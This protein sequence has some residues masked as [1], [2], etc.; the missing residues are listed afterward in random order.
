M[1]NEYQRKR[2]AQETTFDSLNKENNKEKKE[3][4]DFKK[5]VDKCQE[6]LLQ[7]NRTLKQVEEYNLQMRSEIAIKRRTTYKAEEE[8][9]KLEKDKEK[10]DKLIDNLNEQIKYLSEQKA[11]LSTQLA[12]QEE[13]TNNAKQIL[14]EALNEMERIKTSKN[15]IIEDWQNTLKDIQERDKNLTKL[16]QFIV[17]EEL[18]ILTLNS[19]IQGINREHL[20]E[21]ANNEQNLK[22]LEKNAIEQDKLNSLYENLETDL[23]RLDTKV[24]ML[25]KSINFKEEEKHKLEIGLSEVRTQQV[26][27]EDGIVKNQRKIDDLHNAQINNKNLKIANE[28]FINNLEKINVKTDEEKNKVI[29]N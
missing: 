28:N 27:M 21:A 11:V 15:S 6:E 14:K 7:L 3:V 26:I 22:L 1:F 10:Q 9:I 24:Q 16:K 23:S 17:E 5:R 19:E 13:E 8:V 29:E 25:K 20:D 18:K 4:D 12:A 2:E